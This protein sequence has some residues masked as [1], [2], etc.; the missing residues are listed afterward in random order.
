MERGHSSLDD[1][2][3]LLLYLLLPMAAF[4]ANPAF[5][6][7]LT[8]QFNRNAVTLT[9][10]EGK[11]LRVDATWGNDSTANRTNGI[12][13]RTLGVARNGALAGDLIDVGEG[14]YT[15][16]NL[17]KNG[18]DWHFR[19][20]TFVRWRPLADN[21][22]N[23]YAM[24]DDRVTGACTS[25]ITGD[26]RFFYTGSVDDVTV[27]ADVKGALYM[28]NA[29]SKITFRALE[30]Q[31][32]ETT[33]NRAVA[34]VW[35]EHGDAI[36]NIE[37][38]LDPNTNGFSSC[39][40]IY[41]ER[42]TVIAHVKR[43]RMTG[44]AV[45]GS[46]PTTNATAYS[47]FYYG[48]YAESTTA[49]NATVYL[50]GNVTNTAYRLWAEIKEVKGVRGPAA[51]WVT[52]GKFYLTAQVTRSLGGS[53]PSLYGVG[54][55]D[56]W[57]T[58]QK[59]ESATNEV[60]ALGKVVAY[61][62]KTVARIDEFGDGGSLPNFITVNSGTLILKGGSYCKSTSA[63]ARGIV[64]AGGTNRIDQITIDLSALAKTT[65]H[66]IH[67]AGGTLLIDKAT[68]VAPTTTTNVIFAPSAQT[69]KTS[70]LQGNTNLHPNVTV[71]FGIVE[72]HGGTQ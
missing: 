3:T 23:S 4:G 13:F 70:Y 16:N 63:S 42:G 44:N 69:V 43:N 15:N 21:I 40:G 26:G 22:T 51:A 59:A 53:S 31:V 7:F 33:G 5:E 46:D 54:P 20:N 62:G 11:H 12:P 71:P 66:P 8:N 37:D 19:A 18:V 72:I 1:M 32:T 28:Q 6:G 39:L 9:Y 68:L 50:L 38:I 35:V 65:N 25:N 30:V 64:Q 34:A 17:L 55:C 47:M 36:I 52:G 2:K 60:L 48:E 14:S 56:A 61:E 58:I 10:R 29:S 49:D 45:Y 67:I 41:W 57:L 27:S 24:F